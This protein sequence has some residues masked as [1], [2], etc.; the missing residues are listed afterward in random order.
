MPFR[1]AVSI[2][3]AI[4]LAVFLIRCASAQILFDNTKAE[5]AGNADW[6]ID[7]RQPI[8]PWM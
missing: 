2:R 8:P 5:T 7:T 1:F 3:T 6:I 4:A